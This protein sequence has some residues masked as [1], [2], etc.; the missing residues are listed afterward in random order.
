MLTIRVSGTRLKTARSLLGWSLQEAA[1]RSAVNWLT[2]KKYE[3]A[4]EYLPPATVGT[5][6]RLVDALE[7]AG[8][9]FDADG[10]HLDRTVPATKSTVLNDGA[11]A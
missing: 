3:G 1:A 8:V 4:G 7:D 6:N 10:V 5:L 2:I 11:A 9:R